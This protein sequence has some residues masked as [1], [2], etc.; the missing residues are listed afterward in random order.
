MIRCTAKINNRLS[1]FAWS[2]VDSTRSPRRR[3]V[4]DRNLI[5]ACGGKIL[6]RSRVGFCSFLVTG[7]RL[8]ASWFSVVSILYRSFR[9]SSRAPY[10]ALSKT[11]LLT[12]L[13]RGRTS[14]NR[15]REKMNVYSSLSS[16]RRD[17]RRARIF[18]RGEVAKR[19]I[20]YPRTKFR[21]TT[22]SDWHLAETRKFVQFMWYT[23]N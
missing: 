11:L 7:E 19:H 20:I 17:S 1:S 4:G 22:S 12:S 13:L 14:K 21:R 9:L 15:E 2:N 16:R 3:H 23:E 5:V 18:E 8:P 6:A 10:S